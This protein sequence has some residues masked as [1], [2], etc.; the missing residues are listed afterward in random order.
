GQWHP[1]LTL[2]PRTQFE[3]AAAIDVPATV[4]SD[5]R[6]FFVDRAGVVTARQNGNEQP[7]WKWTS[8]DLSGLLSQPVVY[9][10]MLLVGSIDG[11]LRALSRS[12]GEVLFR[13]EGLPT[14]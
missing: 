3:A 14:E 5:G 2:L 8:G 13:I 9:Q 6:R 7:L 12:S 1:V 4:D 10:D 11:D